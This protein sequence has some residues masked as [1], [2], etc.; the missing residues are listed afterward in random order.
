[1]PLTISTDGAIVSNDT[2]VDGAPA[3]LI[4]GNSVQFTN[5]ATGILSSTSFG[6]GAIQLT[7]TGTTI[8]NQAGGRILASDSLGPAIQGSSGTDTIDNYGEISGWVRLGEG[9]DSFTQHQPATAVV[10]LKVDLQGG[11]DSFVQI[12]QTNA[13]VIGGSGIDTLTLSGA[14]STVN[15]FSGFEHLIV[16]AQVTNLQSFSN[17]LSLTLETGGFNNFISSQ[18]PNLDVSL[19]M[20]Q[21]SVGP[22][23]SF[24]A[25]TGGANNDHVNLFSSISGT[26]AITGTTDLGGGADSFSLTLFDSSL[27]LPSTGDVRGGAGD[28]LITIVSR[29][30]LTIDLAK[31]SGF[32]S[33]SL[34]TQSLDPTVTANVINASGMTLVSFNTRV[35]IGQSSLPGATLISNNGHGTLD[36]ATT[37]G[38]YG[39]SPGSYLATPDLA[40]TQIADVSR[41]QT[42]INNGTIV[43]SAYFDI[44]NDSYDGTLGSVGGTIFGFAGNDT[45][46]GGALTDTIDGGWGNDTLNGKGGADTVD[47]AG[48]NDRII[49]DAGADTLLGGA[50][51]DRFEL[52]SGGTGSA[53]DGGADYDTLAVSGSVSLG[54]LVGI[55]LI[56]LGTGGALTL[57][58]TQAFE[59]LPFTAQVI[60]SGSIVI[61]M[62]A[63]VLLAT[64]FWQVASGAELTINGTSGT[65]LL[66]VGDATQTISTG[67]GIDQIKGGDNDDIIDGGADSDRIIGGGGADT[68]TGGGGSDMFRF[69]SPD[70]SVVGIDA[71]WI[72]DF[73]S[74]ED[75]LNFVK[76]DADAA[77]PGDQAFAFIGTAAFANTGLGQIRYEDQ[78]P[79]V[80]V[81]ADVNGDG[82]ADMEI[83]L[84][85]L[86]G[87]P[88]TT[89]DFVL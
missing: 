89:A 14:I 52:A 78:G 1:M 30:A 53:V 2:T 67:A 35:F 49:A 54:G 48:G 62:T 86:A 75:K 61:N 60:G 71:D 13:L 41:S 56:D 43:G 45:L 76:I 85:G 65:D 83:L 70:D 33:L 57:T 37:F 28:D 81:L 77:T 51:N 21:F 59:G 73:V 38:L 79:D 87:E 6:W 40:T 26:G 68:L 82:V 63:G 19:N 29:S 46:I 69:H 24:R 55:E 50:G 34:S 25:I 84:L 22:A 10:Q 12:G 27:A 39:R 11:N 72:T 9:N 64:K 47:G 5:T 23:S 31:F 20:N 58:G 16:G 18:N 8:V 88:L 4:S 44:G 17:L 36:G 15:S 42:L 7:G 32:E 80:S 66:K 3:V 74:G